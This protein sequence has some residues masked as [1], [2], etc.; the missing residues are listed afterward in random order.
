[1]A[2]TV[3]KGLSHLHTEIEKGGKWNIY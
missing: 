3:V 1:M 2:L